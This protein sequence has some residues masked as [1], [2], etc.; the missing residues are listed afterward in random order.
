MIKNDTL[1]I[2]ILNYNG[3]TD[4]IQC[5]KSLSRL[6]VNYDVFIVD[7]FSNIDD[8]LNLKNNLDNGVHLIRTKKNLGYAGGN[9]VGL[10]KA[11]EIGYK[12]YCVLN[13]DT[14]IDDDFAVDCLKLL[15]KN[16][17]IGFIGPAIEDYSSGRIQSAGGYINST[18]GRIKNPFYG[19]KKRQ[20]PEIVFCDYISGACILCR[21]DILKTEGLIPEQYFLFYEET[22]WCYRAKT[23]GYRNICIGK[24]TIKHKGSVSVI[25]IGGNELQSYLMCRNRIAFMRRNT[26]HKLISYLY[27]KYLYCLEIIKYVIKKFDKRYKNIFS[28]YKDGWTKKVNLEKYPFIIINGD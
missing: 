18:I 27:Y 23:H 6:K 13:N 10:K 8:Y 15:A 16:K 28:G 25:N 1:A 20:I 21:D 12:F 2:I 5:V 14:I 26:K 17:N 19:Y 11:L 9:N 24:Y 22:E 4:T 3:S 7:N